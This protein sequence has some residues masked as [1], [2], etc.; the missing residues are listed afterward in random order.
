MQY[1]QLIGVMQQCCGFAGCS[2]GPFHIAMSLYSDKVLHLE[3]RLPYTLYTHQKKILTM[4]S[5]DE[6]VF[7][8]WIKRL[9]SE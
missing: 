5:F 6:N 7:N 4:N 2:S 1:K 3:N 8:E 9:K